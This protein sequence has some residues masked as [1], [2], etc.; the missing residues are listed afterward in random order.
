MVITENIQN[1]EDSHETF[2]L[3]IQKRERIKYTSCQLHE[4]ETA[5]KGNQY[6]SVSE[7]EHL[8]RKI[9]VTESRI[10]VHCCSSVMLGFLQGGVTDQ[11]LNSRVNRRQNL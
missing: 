1:A 3:R 6:P 2:P 8:A 10:Q 4:L 9:G 5:F 7:R 11:C